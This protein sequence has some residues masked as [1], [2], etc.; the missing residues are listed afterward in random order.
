MPIFSS[1]PAAGGGKEK[2]VQLFNA[3]GTWVAPAGVTYAIAHLMSGGGPGGA[4]NVASAVGGNSSAFGTSHTGA[5]TAQEIGFGYTT[6]DY[7]GLD[8]RPNTGQGGS[9]FCQNEQRGPTAPEGFESTI[10][11]VGAVVVPGTSYTITVGAG[12]PRST[13]G[14]GH[15]GGGSGY[16]CVEYWIG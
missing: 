15:A 1:T 3:T 13:S 12:A 2:R 5:S 10:K 14:S 4:Y 9:G 16:V 6:N 7:V 11:K 8:G